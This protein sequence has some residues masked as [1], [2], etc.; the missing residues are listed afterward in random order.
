MLTHLKKS[1]MNISLHLADIKAYF[2]QQTDMQTNFSSTCF[3]YTQF[4]LQHL[5]FL[6]NTIILTC[7]GMINTESQMTTKH[8]VIPQLSC[9][10]ITYSIIHLFIKIAKEEV[11]ASSHVTD[12]ILTFQTPTHRLLVSLGCKEWSGMPL[13]QKSSV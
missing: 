7:S 6:T 12:A 4:G 1:I 2:I 11:K 8:H 10:R 3:G 9:G 13:S 5:K